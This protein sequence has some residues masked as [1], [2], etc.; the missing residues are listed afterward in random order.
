[1]GLLD[2]PALSPSIAAK[3]YTT[4]R[5]STLVSMLQ[6]NFQSINVALL[7]DST[8]NEP[9]EWFYLTISALAAQFPQYT[10]SYRLWNDTSQSYDAAVTVQTGTGANTL[11]VYN[12]SV[13]GTNVT[14]ASDG[15]TA[16]ISA[17]LPVQM[18]TLIF[19]Y[20]YNWPSLTSYREQAT[21]AISQILNFQPRAEVYVCSQPPMAAANTADSP[22]NH[23]LRADSVRAMAEQEGWAIIDA[24]QA[25]LDYGAVNGGWD[26]LIQSDLKH[27]TIGA[28][29]TGSAVWASEALRVLTKQPVTNQRPPRGGSVLNHLWIP[30]TQ[31]A[32][33]SGSPALAWN[34]TVEAHT[35]AFD[36]DAV[37][38]V[39]T[40]AIV[41]PSWA[42]TVWRI[43]WHNPGNTGRCQW[44]LRTGRL[45]SWMGNVT[46]STSALTAIGNVQA[47]GTGAI[48]VHIAQ[49]YD[50]RVPAAAFGGRGV[51]GGFPTKVKVSRNATVAGD[52]SPA[53]CH[54]IGVM[55]ERVG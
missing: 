18:H 34:S 50:G 44:I 14:Y 37:E 10:V 36:P 7:G 3:R 11:Y 20:G 15:G 26:A 42:N 39:A 9:G 32:A 27:P 51:D 16:R 54:L 49:M 46:G 33:V 53:D 47:A 8:G 35:W 45:S 55:V 25:F 22:G 12:G 31:F 52:S 13:P 21:Y 6:R 24:T 43:F 40:T 48:D 4:T 30:A 1:M 2:P 38:E 23:L 5:P 17:M 29:N 41:P 19:S 28:G